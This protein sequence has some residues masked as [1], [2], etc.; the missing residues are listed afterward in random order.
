MATHALNIPDAIDIDVRAIVP[1]QDLQDCTHLLDDFEALNA[2]Y[3]EH[4]YLLFFAVR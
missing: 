1:Q 2:F 3:G 4:G